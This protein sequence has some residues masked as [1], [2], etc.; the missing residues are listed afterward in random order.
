MNL[1]ILD[2]DLG[3]C[4]ILRINNRFDLLL[5]WVEPYHHSISSA[6]SSNS[7]ASLL[8]VGILTINFGGS[9][10]F[11]NGLRICTN[12]IHNPCIVD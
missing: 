11:L 12:L 9:V 5:I 6:M 8:S 3:G 7:A 4:I 2:L 1:K 10:V